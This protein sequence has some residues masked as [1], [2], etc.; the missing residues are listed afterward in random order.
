MAN[1]PS[2][3]ERLRELIVAS[4]IVATLATGTV[5][6]GPETSEVKE[7]NIAAFNIQIFGKSKRGKPEVM[8]PLRDIAHEFDLI[9]VQEV[10]DASL[11]TADVFLD[12]INAEA[13]LTYDMLE[14]N[15][16]GRTNSKEQYVIYYI[17]AKIRFLHA[18]T[19]PDDHDVF[20]REPLIATFQ[21]D[22]FDF[23]L[24][25]CHIKP[26]DVEEELLE[27]ENIVSYILEANPEEEDII[28]LGDFNADGSYLNEARLPEIFPTE[29]YQI[30]ITD[31]MD[32]MTTSDN[33]YDRIILM[34]PTFS[35][36][37]IEDSADV[38][39]FDL[40]L[41][42][43]NEELIQDVSDHYPVFAK[44]KTT[45]QDDD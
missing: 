29:N 43:Y 5:L 35:F 16:L 4:L 25:V 22:N 41:G 45:L 18:Y 37:Y 17:P 2:L 39:K 24:V 30:V 34:E 27:L 33:T 11:T 40:E 44:F 13:D 7:I 15:R 10:R 14:G 32:T 1:N 28:L 21:A 36:E 38:Y 8:S 31:D 12:F 9:V 26:D 3:I 20:E 42:I 6:V 19:W 23:T